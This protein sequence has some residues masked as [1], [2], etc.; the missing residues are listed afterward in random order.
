MSEDS[1]EDPTDSDE[2]L[3]PVVR[4]R[5]PRWVYPIAAVLVAAVVAGAVVA[6][7]G[8]H[9]AKHH[10][11]GPVSSRSGASGRPGASTGG[12]SSAADFGDG[13]ALVG[14]Y[15]FGLGPKAVYRFRI[16]ANGDLR[17]AGA[18]PVEGLDAL[19]P[20]D[21]YH[22]VP[23]AAHHLIWVVGYG[24]APASV[25]AVDSTTLIPR[26]RGRWPAAVTAAAALDGELYLVTLNA[27]VD[28]P[29]GGP[30]VQVDGL[31][32]DYLDA[33]ADPSRHRLLLLDGRNFGVVAFDPT[34]GSVV[35]GQSLALAKGSLALTRRDE[36]WVGGYGSG[37]GGGAV[38]D[39]LDA[40]TLH[41]VAT[42]PLAGRLGPGA[43]LVG[44]GT[45]VVWV[46]AGSTDDPRLWCVDAATGAVDQLWRQPGAV[47]SRH[48]A[49]FV[50]YRHG[51]PSFALSGCPG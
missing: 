3:A 5:V 19:A 36:L 22:L 37:S 34:T 31:T 12:G 42:S 10:T 41:L 27:V 50:E 45:D 23:D 49:A 51:L 28:V 7:T 16:D 21:S 20:A 38:L 48:G 46:R 1:G 6:I 2:V 33:V 18:L 32:S 47:T 24:R 39:R 26:Y 30:P 40:R 15:L 25:L 43:R 11:A 4:P 9:A 17:N 44:A 35:R 13:V 29:V 14:D 8:H